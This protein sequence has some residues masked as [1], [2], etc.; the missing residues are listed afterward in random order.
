MI[1]RA[2]FL[3]KRSRPWIAAFAV[4][5]ATMILIAGFAEAAP[6]V[7][8][9]FVWPGTWLGRLSE[10]GDRAVA[11]LT[12]LLL[13]I[14]CG[15]WLSLLGLGIL[16]WSLRFGYGSLA[17]AR[18]VVDE[19]LRNKTVVVLL[20][21]LLLCLGAWPYFTTAA[22]LKVPQPLRYQIQGFLSFS[23]MLTA[24]LLGAVTILFA[25]YSVSTD[26][27]VR[28]TGDVFVKPLSRFLYLFGK[29][30]G[31]MCIMAVLL[32]VQC[33]LVWGVARLWL[34]RN[35][36][37]DALDME[38]VYDSVLIARSQ[39]IPMPPQPFEQVALDRLA[40]KMRDE[41]ELVARRGRGAIF[42][43]IVAEQQSEFLKIPFRESRTYRFTGLQRAR[44]HALDL[45]SRIAAS[46][47]QLAQQLSE[48]LG[49]PVQPHQI[50]LM[51][52]APYASLLGID[53]R[54]GLLQLRFNVIGIN[55]YA[56]ATGR[57]DVAI[58]GNTLP[59]PLEY[60]I[61]RVQVVD[62][63]ANY[64][65]EN[66]VLLLEF[67]HHY[68]DSTG[69]ARTIQFDTGT[70]IHIYHVE[71]GFGSNLLRATW[72]HLVRLGFL[73]MLG[74]ITGSL[75]SF[76]VAATFSLCLWILAAGGSW[77]Q[78]ALSVGVADTDVAAVDTTFNS[79]MMPVVR[80]ITQMLSTYGRLD[81]GTMLSDGR[82]ITWAA[83]VNQTF[84]V[85]AVWMGVLMALGGYLFWRREIAR[86]QV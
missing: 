79:V 25:A 5:A 64:V 72:I 36:A 31:V 85:G 60:T 46:A 51:S 39:T 47:P 21:L 18:T 43:D 68:P 24:A 8:E 49:T 70:W 71:D 9:G 56:S 83:L 15:A 11:P 58:N 28:R 62:L 45:E 34:P 17:I 78:G 67:N 26:I 14:F 81:V 20:S 32:A 23:A 6:G 12:G 59:R 77:L 75:W 69:R 2:G 54:P 65:D 80:L 13:V 4:T 82:Y 22:A 37:I 3:L 19:A 38:A 41:P 53:L 74:V 61:D 44:Q 40:V 48:L 7:D 84:W 86:V 57:I 55:S 52:L 50:S 16:R 63:P 33:G 66:G 73:A 1:A 35:E 42:A 10:A 27:N 76:P 29:W 30:L